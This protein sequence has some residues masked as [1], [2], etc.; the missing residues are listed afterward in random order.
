MFDIFKEINSKFH[1][2]WVVE[3]A[4]KSCHIM[5]AKSDGKSLSK[6]VLKGV[7]FLGHDFTAKGL[8]VSDPIEQV[9]NLNSFFFEDCG[10]QA[11]DHMVPEGVL[12]D[13][14]IAKK[15]GVVISL[16]LIYQFLALRVNLKL[17]AVFFPDFR[18]FKFSTS[19][20]SFYIDLK[21]RGSLL[22]QD[23]LLELINEV[24]D[25]EFKT[26]CFESLTD[27]E[28][29]LNYLFSI[30]LALGKNQKEKLKAV[31][32]Q[33]LNLKP[34]LLNYLNRRAVI[35]FEL[36]HQKETLRDIKRYFSFAKPGHRPKHLEDI[37]NQIKYPN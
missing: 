4:A 7:H 37:F 2:H 32:D 12:L 5:G 35:T 6:Q 36:G 20:Q 29:Y 33:I 23:Q 31:Y 18:L 13:Q 11:C 3:K 17:K 28:H 21:N 15:K 30:E 9:K 27:E 22:S 1:P 16:G 25:V 26:K 8:K 34:N 19:E 24:S 10:F 14:V